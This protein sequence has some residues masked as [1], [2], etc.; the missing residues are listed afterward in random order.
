[1]AP[2]SLRALPHAPVSMPLKWSEVTRKLDPASFTLTTV[3]RRLDKVG[4]LFAQ[5]LAGGQKLP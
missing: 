1:V 4:D 5:A 3:R 2:Y